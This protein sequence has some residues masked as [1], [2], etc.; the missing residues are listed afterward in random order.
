MRSV[1]LLVHT[2][3]KA[4]AHGSHNYSLRSSE[5]SWN[6]LVIWLSWMCEH[7]ML[8]L[9]RTLNALE[10]ELIYLHLFYIRTDLPLTDRSLKVFLVIC[11]DDITLIGRTL[12]VDVFILHGIQVTLV[13]FISNLALLSKLKVH[14]V[15]ASIDGADVVDWLV[16]IE[17]DLLVNSFIIFKPSSLLNLLVVQLS[18]KSGV[19]CVKVLLN[20]L[21]LCPNK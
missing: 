14:E 8:F 11:I 7:V 19:D 9:S 4:L 12:L 17:Y 18:F 21:A 3:Q 20:R 10:C 5:I 2:I 6:V 16:E 13:V 15:V 1:E